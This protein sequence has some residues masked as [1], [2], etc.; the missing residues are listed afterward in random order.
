MAWKNKATCADKEVVLKILR[1]DPSQGYG[2]IDGAM[3]AAI[4]RVPRR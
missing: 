1:E 2:R 4:F 3:D